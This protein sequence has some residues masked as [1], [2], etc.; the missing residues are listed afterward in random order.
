MIKN[1]EIKVVIN[2]QLKSRSVS[3]VEETEQEMGLRHAFQVLDTGFSLLWDVDEK[4]REKHE[5]I[6]SQLEELYEELGQ[7]YHSGD[8]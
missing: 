4:F 2:G 1:N 7:E 6:I 8:Y 5:D 3:T